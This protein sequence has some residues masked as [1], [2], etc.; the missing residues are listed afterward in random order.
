MNSFGVLLTT[1]L[2]VML[3]N[4]LTMIGVSPSVINLVKGCMLLGVISLGK[5]F[6]LVDTHSFL[7]KFKGA[8]GK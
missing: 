5:I 1:I 4:G 2:I 7:R 6:D 8:A 3:A